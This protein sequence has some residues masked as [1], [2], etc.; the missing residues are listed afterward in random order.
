MTTTRQRNEGQVVNNT[1]ASSEV[2]SIVQSVMNQVNN[3]PSNRIPLFSPESDDVNDWIV[4]FE[5]LTSRKVEQRVELLP[6]VLKKKALSWYASQYRSLNGQVRSWDEW[7]AALQSEFGRSVMAILNELCN[8]CQRDNETPHE[9][10]QSVIGLCSL[11]NPAMTEV[12]KI[13]HL[14]R[15][16]NN[17]LREKMILMCPSTSQDFLDKL[18]RIHVNVPSRMK[19]DQSNV[20]EIAKALA[21]KQQVEPSL[22]NVDDKEISI[23]RD[24]LKNL[25]QK[26]EEMCIK[27]SNGTNRYQD[28]NRYSGEARTC[29]YCGA[30]GHLQND[31]RK[32][33]GDDYRQRND[34]QYRQRGDSPRRNSFSPGR[35][36]NGQGRW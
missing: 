6:T 5:V 10:Y 18:N 19:D 30:R 25:S 13:N 22:L 1:N 34:H 2:S 16:L 8:R 31:C 9:Y 20:V 33:R 11:S 32:K 27:N 28:R 7:K 4:A 17:G 23:L 3:G 24:E 21:N 12:E 35:Q 26:M 15:G 36:G 29:Y 14:L